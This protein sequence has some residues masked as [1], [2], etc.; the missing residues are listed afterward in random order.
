MTRI[1]ESQLDK[2]SDTDR[3]ALLRT[4]REQAERCTD[5]NNPRV[6]SWAKRRLRRLESLGG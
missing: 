5:D 4:L 1:T 3:G 2:L 6:R